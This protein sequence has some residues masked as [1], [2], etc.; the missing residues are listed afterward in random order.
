MFF[1]HRTGGN[2]A[3][4]IETRSISRHIEYTSQ[5]EEGIITGIDTTHTSPSGKDYKRPLSRLQ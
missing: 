5:L 3:A 1:Q 2:L 4:I